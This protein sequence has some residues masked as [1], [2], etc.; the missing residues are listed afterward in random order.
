MGA[1]EVAAEVL[2]VSGVTQ[3]TGG[4]RKQLVIMGQRDLR[5]MSEGTWPTARFLRHPPVGVAP[6]S[7]L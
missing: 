5:R 4:V 6:V 1:S 2:S 3:G 7:L